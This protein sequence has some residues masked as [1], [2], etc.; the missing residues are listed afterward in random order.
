MAKLGSKFLIQLNSMTFAWSTFSL[1]IAF[2][3]KD[4]LYNNDK[5]S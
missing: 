3:S 4:H 5:A 2:K 1:S